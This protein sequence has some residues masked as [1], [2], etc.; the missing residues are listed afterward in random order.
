MHNGEGRVLSLVVGT[1]EQ[2]GEDADH[3]GREAGGD[4]PH[5]GSRNI[6]P[7]VGNFVGNMNDGIQTGIAPV[8][9]VTGNH[10]RDAI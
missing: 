1:G 2:E 10:R 8:H 3:A 6:L 5:E 4:C 7:R 9:A